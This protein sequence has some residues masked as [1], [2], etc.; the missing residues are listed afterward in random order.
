[1][2]SWLIRI[3]ALIIF[4]VAFALPALRMN[5][6]TQPFMGW[7]C[8]LI[9]S[10]TGPKELVQSLGQG[11]HVEDVLI[12]LGGLVNYFFVAVLVLS[13][14]RRL[15]RTRLIVGALMI[16]CFAATWTF[17]ASQKI[18][19][20]AGHYLWVAGAVLLVVPDLVAALVRPS[21]AGMAQEDPDLPVTTHRGSGA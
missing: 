19:P 9:A 4:G 11:I 1:M 17:F 8:A 2:K 10:V 13:F 7:M 16:P 20:L 12:V 14:W 5:G 21:S 15:V 18:A 6:D 3:A